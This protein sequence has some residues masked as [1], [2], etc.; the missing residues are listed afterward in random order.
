[1]VMNAQEQLAL[2]D[3]HT[4]ETMR[5]IA[6]QKETITQLNRDDHAA[7]LAETMLDALEQSLRA[8][9]RHRALI[10]ERLKSAKRQ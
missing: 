2:V 10:L 9:E 1:M 6:L 7:D 8:V 3:R 5:H 4:A